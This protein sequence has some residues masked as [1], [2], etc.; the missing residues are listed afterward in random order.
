MFL[1]LF[2]SSPCL[3]VTVESTVQYYDCVKRKVGEEQDIEI[4]EVTS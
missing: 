1:N 4:V 2:E 3:M